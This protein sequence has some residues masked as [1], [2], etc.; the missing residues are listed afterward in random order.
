MAILKSM[1]DILFDEKLVTTFQQQQVE[2]DRR[3]AEFRARPESAENTTAMNKF[4]VESSIDLLC[5]PQIW[6]KIVFLTTISFR[7]ETY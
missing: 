3:I 4:I 2:A 7:K 5:P 1:T 6:K